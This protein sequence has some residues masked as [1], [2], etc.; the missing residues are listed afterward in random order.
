M[1]GNFS[2]QGAI[3]GRLSPNRNAGGGVGGSDT[4]APVLSSP[5]GTKTGSTTADL[6]VATDSVE[7]KMWW[8]VVLSS[9]SAPSAAEIEAGHKSGGGAAP[10]TNGA[11]GTTVTVSPFTAS[12]T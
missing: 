10:A 11:G 7:G 12:A 9:D 6:S 8:V 1:F 4:T 3:S 5:T 2:R